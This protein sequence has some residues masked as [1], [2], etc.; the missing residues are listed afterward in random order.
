MRRGGA[1]ANAWARALWRARVVL[2][3]GGCAA[4]AGCGGLTGNHEDVVNGKALFVS[5]CG[6]CHTLARAD[7]KGTTGPNLDAA[8]QRARRDGFKNSAFRGMVEG[9]IAHP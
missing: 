6:T 3:L 8:F 9:Q 5:K 7:T 1:E 2:A 4:A